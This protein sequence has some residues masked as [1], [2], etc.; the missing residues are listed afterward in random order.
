MS[1]ACPGCGR[2][3]DAESFTGGRTIHCACG[4]RVGAEPMSR[5]GLGVGEHRFFA[6]AMLG[7]LARWLRLLGFDTAYAPHVADGELVRRALGEGRVILSRDRRLP[8]EWRVRGVYLVKDE[9]PLEQLREVAAHF[10]L[11]GRERP[12]SRCCLCNGPLRPASH[13]EA[14]GHVPTVVLEARDE[15]SQCPACRRFYWNGSHVRRIVRILDAAL[16]EPG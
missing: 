7:R 5:P 8:E 11:L 6:D 12:F 10:Q 1:V 13:A 9:R 15:L 16:R 3:Y 4:S 2:N 14:R